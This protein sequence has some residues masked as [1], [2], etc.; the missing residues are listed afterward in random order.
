MKHLEWFL[1]RL[2]SLLVFCVV[3]AI[4]YKVVADS[5]TTQVTVANAAPSFTAGPAED[6]ASSATT[7]T[8]VG[9]L[10]TFKATAQI[11]TMIRIGSRFQSNAIT[12]MERERR[13]VQ[14]LVSRPRRIGVE[15]SCTCAYRRCG[16]AGRVCSDSQQEHVFCFIS[17]VGTSAPFEVNHC[18]H[19]L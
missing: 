12:P 9:N 4:S 1:Q 2:P 18:L 3:G 19:L 15:A 7:P 13:R 10:V 5:V 16:N 11:R 6:P 17:G 8:N 14:G